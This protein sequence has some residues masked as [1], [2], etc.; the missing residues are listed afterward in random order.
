MLPL[1]RRLRQ[2][3]APSLGDYY[4]T[5]PHPF[6]ILG[7]DLLPSGG[8]ERGSASKSLPQ[9]AAGS[10][11]LGIPWEG[12]WPGPSWTTPSALG[13]SEKKKRKEN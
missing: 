3:E 8:I 13:A 6:W 10:A 11:E 4:L 1:L 9:G 12:C 7:L 2:G 5:A